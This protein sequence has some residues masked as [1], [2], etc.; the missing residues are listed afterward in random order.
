MRQTDHSGKPALAFID[1]RRCFAGNRGF[2]DIVDVFCVDPI[3]SDGVPVDINCQILLAT[4]AIDTG[5]LRTLDARRHLRDLVCLGHERFQVVAVEHDRDVR[6]YSRNHLVHTVADRLRHHQV[7][8]GQ[9][10]Q[11]FSDL[12]GDLV[13]RHAMRPL[14]KGRQRRHHVRFIRTRWIRGR[15]AASQLGRQHSQLREPAASAA[16]S[17]SPSSEIRRARCS[18]RDRRWGRAY[19]PASPG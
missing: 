15:F 16:A 6:A 10:C 14:V 4:H 12:L 1:V 13:L 7:D 17:P 9:C 3:T 19:P 11:L 18:A 5:V 8:A 2:D